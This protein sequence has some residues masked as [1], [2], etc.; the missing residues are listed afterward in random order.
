MKDFSK[1]FEPLSYDELEKY[2][3][4]SKEKIKTTRLP[5]LLIK[6]VKFI[7]NNLKNKFL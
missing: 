4:G 6:I 5:R 3:G 1:Y 7:F 2:T